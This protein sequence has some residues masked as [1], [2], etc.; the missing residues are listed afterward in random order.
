MKTKRIWTIC[1]LAAFALAF[2]PAPAHAATFTVISTADSGVGTLR[3]AINQANANVGAD[4]IAFNIAGCGG[5]CVIELASALPLLTDDSTT[6]DGYTQP[7]ASPATPSAPAVILIEI[8]GINITANNGLNILSANNVVRGLAI[9]RFGLV[10]IAIGYAEAQGNVIAGNYLGLDAGGNQERG[11][12]YNGVFIGYGAQNNTIGGDEPAERNVIADNGWEGVSIYGAGTDGNVVS[13]N[14]I[15]SFFSGGVG[16]GNGF[17]VRIY[18][19]ASYNVVGGDTAGE[20]NVIASNLLDGIVLLTGTNNIISGNYIGVAADGTSSASNSRH[21]IRLDRGVQLTQVGGSTAGERNI[22]SGNG[23]NGIFITGTLTMDNAIAGNY[24]GLDAAGNRHSNG[25]N[26]VLL[27][28]GAHDNRI[29]GSTAGERNV[30][31]GNDGDGIRIVGSDTTGNV[32]VGNYVGLDPSGTNYYRN[33]YGIWLSAPGNTVGGSTEGERNVI[34]ANYWVGVLI[35]GTVATNNIIAGNYIGTNAAGAAGLP[36]LIGVELTAGA[37]GNTIG[38]DTAG[39]RNVISANSDTGVYLMG[40]GVTGNLIS[41]NYIGTDASGAVDLGNYENGVYISMGAQGNTIGGDAPGEGNVIAGS[42]YGVYITTTSATGNVVS[43]NYIGTDA[44]GAVALLNGWGVFLGGGASGNQVGGTAAERNVISGN[45]EGVCIEG[46]ATTGNL[47]AGNYIGL[48]ASGTAALGNYTG[49]RVLG[50]PGN[51]VGGETGNVIAG[52]TDSGIYLSDTLGMTVSNNYIGTDPSGTLDLGNGWHGIALY[53]DLSGSVVGGAGAG[54]VVSGNSSDGIHLYGGGGV[55][56]SGNRIGT[57]ASGMTALANGWSGLAI[58]DSAGNTIGGSTVGERNVISGNN[59][60]QVVL[61]NTATTAN[62]VAGNYIGVDATGTAGFGVNGCGVRINGGAHQNTI[63]GSTAGQRNLISGN[64][65][66]VCLGDPGTDDN[67]VAGNYIGADLN[68]TAAVS[69]TYGGVDI[70]GGARNNTIGGVTEGA[71]NVIS[72]NGSYGISVEGGGTDGN[73]IA[74]NFIGVD[75]TGMAALGNEYHGV[76]VDGAI[77]TVI[78]GSDEGAGNIISGNDGSGIYLSEVT[79]TLVAGNSI[80]LDMAGTGVISNSRA[81]VYLS[82]GFDNTIGGDTAGERNVISGNGGEGLVLWGATVSTTIAGNYIGTDAAGAA[83]RG[84]TYC[85]ISMAEGA[86]DNLVGGTSAAARNVVAGN[87]V[88]VCLNGTGTMAN[89][90]AGNYIGLDATGMAALGNQY[91]G[92][93]GWGSGA[94]TIGG[95][96]AGAGNVISGNGSTGICLDNTSGYLIAGNLI[97]VDAAGTAVISNTSSGIYLSTAATNTIG[98]STVGAGNVIA[99]N[100]G[101]GIWLYGAGVTGNTIVGNVIGTDASGTLDLG[102][103]NGGICL[104]EGASGNLVGPGNLIAHNSGNGIIASGAS[105]IAN[106]ITQNAIWANAWEG[107]SLYDGAHNGIAAPVILAAGGSPVQV[108]GTA[109]PGC[110]VELFG[111]SDD[112]GEGE[113]YLGTAVADGTGAFAITLSA[114]DYPYLTATATDAED[115]TSEFSTVFATGVGYRIFL[116][117]VVKG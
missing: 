117:I 96:E 48:D 16:P 33:Q 19:G 83:A 4:T 103:V 14:Y 5:V 74:G 75:V 42:M 60:D 98:G 88:G 91:E 22:I 100:A 6:I 81:G 110:T 70:F 1:W 115:G 46:A 58:E 2:L 86:H 18:G 26:G 25:E 116:P 106:V 39:E 50:A 105:T 8:N 24:I 23:T 65:T 68:G 64:Q 113:V 41:G 9:N 92:I 85:G 12:G 89:V 53:G 45:T 10:G 32:V 77:G 21:G 59:W 44:S 69:N 78:G 54:N 37:N 101:Y 20:R 40:S 51:I 79:G 108:T 55:T 95:D 30:I 94:N 112:D 43:G 38:G 80:G 76:N 73:V 11:N 104:S 34:S 13:G 61:Y 52:N 31:S 114:L 63:G 56:I 109:C 82:G 17:G 28:A 29:G 84:N 27:Q 93:L 7:G 66:G 90:I 97:G 47:I 71:R 99:G 57:D 62:T 111:N 102:N 15:G 107:I 49:L 35:S 36:N 3:W 87:S 72:G 67:V